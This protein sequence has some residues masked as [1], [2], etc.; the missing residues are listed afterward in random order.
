MTASL[1]DEIVSLG[2]GIA[3]HAD[4]L[5]DLFE[6]FETFDVDQS[7]STHWAFLVNHG[8]IV[9]NADNGFTAHPALFDVIAKLSSGVNR[10]TQAPDIEDWLA[11]LRHLCEGYHDALSSGDDSAVHVR[12]R[13]I[14]YEVHHLIMMLGAE[15]SDLEY[16]VDTQFGHVSTLKAKRQE[17]QFLIE[18]TDRLT[19]KLTSITR[20]ELR[21]FAKGSPE[22]VQLL[23]G[24][25]LDG[26]GRRINAAKALNKRLQV[27]LWKY[28]RSDQTAKLVRSFEKHCSIHGGVSVDVLSDEELID[29]IFNRV[30]PMPLTGAPNVGDLDVVERYIEIANSIPRREERES[31]PSSESDEPTSLV[32]ESPDEVEVPQATMEPEYRRFMRQALD[33]RV[34]ARDY[35]DRQDRLSHRPS[36]WMA[37]LYR[38]IRDDQK[39]TRSVRIDM[40]LVTDPVVSMQGTEVVRDLRVSLKPR[41]PSPGAMEEHA[42]G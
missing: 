42:H 20:V 9:G 22:L 15:I 10:A 38:R 12:R 6:N 30:A 14:R 27:M 8:L 23:T 31:R 16:F 11:N 35:W 36:V 39:R 4:E 2:K 29:S 19:K 26:L 25:L 5:A 7:R 28:R 34:S 41:G 17:N 33:H 32:V 18:R 1:R 21:N 13:Q 24:H 40:D 3:S 37:W